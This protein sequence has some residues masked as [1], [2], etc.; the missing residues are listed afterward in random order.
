MLDISDLLSGY[1]VGSDINDFVKITIQ[2][3]YRTDVQID[4]DGTGG[5]QY[6]GIIYGNFTGETVDGLI[7]SGT[8]IVQ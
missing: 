1:G 4:A 7:S 8:F 6:A 3:Q 5:F 2:D